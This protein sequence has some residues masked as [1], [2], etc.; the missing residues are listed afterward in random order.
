MNCLQ[1]EYPLIALLMCGPTCTPQRSPRTILWLGEDMGVLLA[2][3][4]VW[5]MFELLN[6]RGGRTLLFVVDETFLYMILLIFVV[7]IIVYPYCLK[8]PYWFCLYILSGQPPW[9]VVLSS[10]P[11]PQGWRGC[12]LGTPA[13]RD[14]FAAPREPPG[15]AGDGFHGFLF[16]SINDDNGW[17]WLLLISNLDGW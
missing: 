9:S 16:P 11:W 17:Q 15:D 1:V 4:T 12:A 6:S 3:T 14:V 5:D 2:W 10:G 7:Y 13:L 8:Y